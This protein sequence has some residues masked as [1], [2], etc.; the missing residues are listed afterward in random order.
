MNAMPKYQLSIR[1]SASSFAIIPA[2]SLEDMV[3]QIHAWNAGAGDYPRSFQDWLR[4][5]DPDAIAM[6]QAVSLICRK[7]DSYFAED[8]ATGFE[9]FLDRRAAH[10]TKTDVRR[11]AAET[12]N[13]D[14]DGGQEAAWQ[15]F[16]GKKIT[17]LAQERA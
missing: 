9:A 5:S 1:L 12:L 3:A 10:P 13:P 8:A 7:A 6:E 4:N 11:Y 2:D 15:I 17:Q 14:A 16:A